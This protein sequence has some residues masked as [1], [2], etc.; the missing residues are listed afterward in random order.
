MGGMSTSEL[1]KQS[2]ISY[3]THDP[4][5]LKIPSEKFLQLVAK[6]PNV[7]TLIDLGAGSG[8][9][10]NWFVDQR[11]GHAYCLDY[12]YS[13]IHVSQSN[14]QRT[15]VVFDFGKDLLTEL[16]FT[17]GPADVLLAFQIFDHIQSWHFD[18]LLKEILTLS[19]L[20]HIIVSFL[21]T[22]CSG[23]NIVGAA[24]DDIHYVSPI[25]TD[26]RSPRPLVELHRFFQP[27]EI[28]KVVRTLS[29]WFK[30]DFKIKSREE[31]FG[32]KTENI[33]CTEYFLFSRK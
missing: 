12:A 10:S 4:A 30:V 22:E 7:R 15:N 6:V 9:N 21:T 27:A 11:K 3:Y 26:D 25:L 31:S 32:Q 23:P 20:Q 5:P 24:I 16:P 28:D 14:E 1:V 13:D 18:K 19:H 2:W 33:M 29:C 17:Q 8:N